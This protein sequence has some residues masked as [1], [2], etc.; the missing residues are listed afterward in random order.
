MH[1]NEFADDL[2]AC[3]LTQSDEFQ[4]LLRS[5]ADLEIPHDPDVR[6]ASRNTVVRHLRLHFLEWGDPDAPP[7][8]LIH[9]GNQSAHS[10]DLVSL[11]LADRFHVYA[12]DQ[13]GHG[14]S[15]WSRDADYSVPALTADARGFIAQLGLVDPIIVGHSLGGLVTMTLAA[16]SPSLPRA[17]VIVDTA[18]EISH[19]GSQAVRNFILANAEFDSI[20]QFVE[21][22]VKYDPYRSPEHIQRTVR[23]NLLERAD[24]RF[25][26]KSDRMLHDAEFA[27]R[28]PMGAGRPV[29]IDS[30]RAID[31]PTLVVRGGESEVLE[32]DSAERFASAL[33]RGQLAE[34][35]KAGHNVHGQN[36]PG[37]L[38]AVRPFL[39]AL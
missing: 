20:D 8:V 27:K 17:L 28:R 15:E 21:R 9:G 33:P 12:L 29:N 26:A 13:R 6:Y 24:G 32:R 19:E 10:W 36:T 31:C 35:P 23:Y 16:E 39:D 37:F 1:L 11:H 4:S 5:A 34:V 7:L 2:A 14:D 18:P 3:D 25:I 38:E 22:V 30:V